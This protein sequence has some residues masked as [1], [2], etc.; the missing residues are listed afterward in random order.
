MGSFC[1]SCFAVHCDVQIEIGIAS[2]PTFDHV[3]AGH[4]PF[5]AL[6]HRTRLCRRRSRHDLDG[7]NR[8]LEARKLEYIL[9][10]RER[11]DAIVRQIV[12]ANN[13]PFVPLLVERKAGQTQLFVKQV[14]IEGKRYVLCRNRKRPRRTAG[15]ARRSSPRSTRNL[16]RAKREAAAARSRSAATGATRASRRR[17]AGAHRRRAECR[18]AVPR[19][20][21][22]TPA[23][24]EASP[25][26]R[27]PQRHRHPPRSAAHCPQQRPGFRLADIAIGAAARVIN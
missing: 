8:G 12:L 13:D 18:G 22:R 11:T 26:R 16:R 15:T 4:R 2:R 7:D 9:G 5:A 24:R 6:L 20:S 17:L 14:T 1:H 21:Y 10:A 27:R 3:A 25:R 19:R 23:A